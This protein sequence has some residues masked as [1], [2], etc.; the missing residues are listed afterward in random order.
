[1]FSSRRSYRV[2]NLKPSLVILDIVVAVDLAILITSLYTDIDGLQDVSLA[3]SVALT[4]SLSNMIASRGSS[5]DIFSEQRRAP[6]AR[7][8]SGAG[9]LNKDSTDPCCQTIEPCLASERRPTGP[10]DIQ[11]SSVL[12]VCFAG[13]ARLA[14]SICFTDLTIPQRGI[15]E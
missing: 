9:K 13:A 14:V 5:F 7:T 11:K 6:K 8:S 12:T 15:L 4:G 1:M 2:T 3:C 10:R